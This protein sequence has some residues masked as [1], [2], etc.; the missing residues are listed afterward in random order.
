MLAFNHFLAKHYCLIV[1]HDTI[2]WKHMPDTFILNLEVKHTG[3][4]QTLSNIISLSNMSFY[5]KYG[6]ISLQIFIV[7]YVYQFLLNC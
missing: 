3:Y 1:L 4:N 2:V 7:Q 5:L 6:S